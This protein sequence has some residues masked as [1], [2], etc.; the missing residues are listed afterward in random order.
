MAGQSP[1][2]PP[3]RAPVG[4][5]V[6]HAGLLDG[7]LMEKEVGQLSDPQVVA[8]Q[9]F[10]ERR[11]PQLGRIREPRPTIRFEGKPAA[12]SDRS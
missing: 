7:K 3:D 10:L 11:H 6:L 9:T 12:N 1:F 5:E 2:R 8:S 4:V